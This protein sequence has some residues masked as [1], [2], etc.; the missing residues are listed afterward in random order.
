MEENQGATPE[1][2]TRQF[3]LAKLDYT[4]LL[5]QEQSLMDK[6]P[7]VWRDQRYMTYLEG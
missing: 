4:R 6:R 2:T 5:T 3:E 1:Q 7:E